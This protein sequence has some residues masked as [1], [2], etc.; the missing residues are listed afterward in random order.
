MIA[1]IAIVLYEALD[2]EPI[3]PAHNEA[4]RAKVDAYFLGA[5]AAGA[6]AAGMAPCFIASVLATAAFL[7]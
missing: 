2:G 5:G 4:C 6:A 1:K 7:P 3:N